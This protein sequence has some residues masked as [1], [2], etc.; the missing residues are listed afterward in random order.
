MAGWIGALKTTLQRAETSHQPRPEND[1][2]VDIPQ[3]LIL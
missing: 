2:V 3:G 1:N